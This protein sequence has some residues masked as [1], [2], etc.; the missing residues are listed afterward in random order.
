[1]CQIALYCQGYESGLLTSSW[2]TMLCSISSRIT[3]PILEHLQWSPKVCAVQLHLFRKCAHS[4][5]PS[6]SPLPTLISLLQKFASSFIMR[7]THTQLCKIQSPRCM[8]ST[9]THSAGVV[10]LHSM[11]SDNE[12]PGRAAEPR[13]ANQGSSLIVLTTECRGSSLSCETCLVLRVGL[14]QETKSEIQRSRVKRHEQTLFPAFLRSGF[15]SGHPVARM[16]N[17]PLDFV[18]QYTLLCI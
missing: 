9:Y 15:I 4:F 7:V 17:L 12:S 11:L 1:M 16:F 13:W 14:Q 5:M 10:L 18:N 2:S 8:K 3:L 6:Y